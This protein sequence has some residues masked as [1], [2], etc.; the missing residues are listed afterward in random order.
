MNIIFTELYE[1]STHLLI[2]Q[3]LRPSAEV[4]MIERMFLSD[5]RNK[6]EADKKLAAANKGS[7]LI[8]IKIIYIATYLRGPNF[9]LFSRKFLC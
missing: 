5:E 2:L 4:V 7:F 1:H 9:L 8:L 3:R 6:L